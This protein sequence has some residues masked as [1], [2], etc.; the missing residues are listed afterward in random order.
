MINNLESYI[1]HELRV[2]FSPFHT[3]LMKICSRNK[4]ANKYIQNEI[5]FEGN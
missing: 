5:T 1:I 2:L 3:R 4:S